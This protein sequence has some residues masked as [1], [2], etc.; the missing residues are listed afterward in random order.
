[1][2][3][4]LVKKHD[5]KCRP[6]DVSGQGGKHGLRNQYGRYCSDLRNQ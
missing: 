4:N 5:R 3:N 2:T 6:V 1:M